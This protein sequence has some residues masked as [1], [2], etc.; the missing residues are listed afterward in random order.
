MHVVFTDV[1]ILSSTFS[2]DRNKKQIIESTDES[3]DDVKEQTREAV[4]DSDVN[5]QSD[6]EDQND[7]RDQSDL[8]DQSDGR[9]Q[10]D[11]DDGADEDQ[12][13]MSRA[14]RMS[15]MGIVPKDVDSDD[16]D[17]IQSDE[18]ST[19]TSFIHAKCS[20]ISECEFDTH[21]ITESPNTAFSWL[22]NGH[23]TI[24]YFNNMVIDGT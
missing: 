19:D 4:D 22:L 24:T 5:K 16:S 14:T 17:Y 2:N 18:V 1:K 12:L 9:D 23:V 6:V 13:V 20:S 8:E 10:S 11:P 15:I 7:G 21:V 3:D